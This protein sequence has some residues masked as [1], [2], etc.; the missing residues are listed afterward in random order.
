MVGELFIEPLCSI[1][2]IDRRKNTTGF[3]SSWPGV[4][5][6]LQER[7]SAMSKYV[8]ESK[9]GSPLDKLSCAAVKEVA[10]C[11]RRQMDEVEFL[12]D[13]TTVNGKILGEMLYSPLTNSWCESRQANMDRIVKFSG[14]STSLQ[15]LSN[16]EVVSGNK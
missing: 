15:T 6:F 8:E 9:L 12:R 7:L 10:V 2:C 5:A 16:K 4:K 1:L 13:D 3:E 14:G 11:V